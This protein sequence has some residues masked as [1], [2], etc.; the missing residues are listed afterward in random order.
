MAG[1]YL[2]SGGGYWGRGSSIEAAIKAA[3]WLRPGDKVFVAECLP[4]ARVDDEG[5][6]YGLT[7]DWVHGKLTSRGYFKP[8]HLN[9]RAKS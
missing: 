2:I 4:N 1:H 5:H 6:V 3:K 8:D 9:P 7:G